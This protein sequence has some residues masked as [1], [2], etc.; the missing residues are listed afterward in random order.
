LLLDGYFHQDFRAE[1]GT[2]ESA[3]RAFAREA[4]PDELRAART[5]LEAFLSWAE[6]LETETWQAAL[7]AAGG[8]WRP[9]SVG[10]LRE[11]LDELR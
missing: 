6:G 7:S 1:H 11:V 4:S 5:A 9:R 10:P 8:A 3:A 2:H